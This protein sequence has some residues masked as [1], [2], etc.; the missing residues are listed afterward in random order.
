MVERH[1]LLRQKKQTTEKNHHRLLT[2]CAKGAPE[3]FFFLNPYRHHHNENARSLTALTL[4]NII[5]T[6]R[7]EP[8]TLRACLS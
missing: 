6:S 5:R 3:S 7:S 1:E 8:R 2:G 4:L